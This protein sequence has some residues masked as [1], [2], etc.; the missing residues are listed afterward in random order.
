[1]H[2]KLYKNP[3]ATGWKGWIENGK[4]RA[5]AFVRPSGEIVWEW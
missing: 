2:L 5:L 4:G 3:E 1:M